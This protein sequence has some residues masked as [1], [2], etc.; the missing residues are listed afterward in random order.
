MNDITLTGGTYAG[1][2]GF[3]CPANP[4]SGGTIN[5]VRVGA[6]QVTQTCTPNG[7]AA[8]PPAG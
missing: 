3:T 7:S 2:F 6:F 5:G 1:N 4:I 8:P